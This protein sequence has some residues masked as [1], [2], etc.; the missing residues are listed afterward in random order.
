MG[1]VDRLCE[2]FGE[3]LPEGGFSFPEP[4]RLAGLSVEDLAPLRCGFRARYVLDAARRVA[5]GELPLDEVAVLPLPEAREALQTIDGVGPKW[6]ECA[7]LYGMP[8]STPF[9]W[10]CGCA[11][12]CRRCFPGKSPDFFGPFAGIAQQY[13]FITAAFIRNCLGDIVK[14]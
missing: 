8:G 5:G 11:A 14:V 2:N 4:E 7:L 6:R 10:T 9:P 13:V 12:R 3:P 1:I